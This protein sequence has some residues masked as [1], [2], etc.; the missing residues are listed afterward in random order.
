MKIK[1]K[2]NHSLFNQLDEFDRLCAEDK[3][4]Q[5]VSLLKQLAK[6]SHHVPHPG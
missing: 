6:F 1:N 2:L 3:L 4:I 5:R